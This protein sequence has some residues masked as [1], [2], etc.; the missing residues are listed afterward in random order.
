MAFDLALKSPPARQNRPAT[1]R[2]Q[3]KKKGCLKGGL[4]SRS[5]G[6]IPLVLGIVLAF[7]IFELL[8]GL[9]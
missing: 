1:P 2:L 4:P 8:C 9:G 3:G 6:L 7:Y 5:P